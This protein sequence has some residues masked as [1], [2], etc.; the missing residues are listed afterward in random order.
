MET[1]FN[2][3]IKKYGVLYVGWIVEI[4][5]KTLYFH[6]KPVVY[7]DSEIKFLYFFL[8]KKAAYRKLKKV[9]EEMENPNE[10]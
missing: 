7:G 10:L 9:S 2:Y 6:N 1:F 5:K 3:Y 8:T 4:T